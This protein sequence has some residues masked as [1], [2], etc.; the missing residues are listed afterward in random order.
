MAEQRV[1]LDAL[2]GQSRP[3]IC[4]QR[5]G[6][7][8]LDLRIGNQAVFDFLHSGHTGGK[9]GRHL[10]D[11]HGQD[12]SAQ[13][14]FPVLWDHFDVRFRNP[15]RVVPAKCLLDCGDDSRHAVPPHGNLFGSS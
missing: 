1:D 13:R 3:F 2:C 5:P 6:H 7:R 8:L 9:I 15:D 11:R 12:V 10:L 4:S 14:D